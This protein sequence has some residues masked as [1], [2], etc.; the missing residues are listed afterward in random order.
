MGVEPRLR[1]HHQTFT[2]PLRVILGLDP[3]IRSPS[4]S[5]AEVVRAALS[6]QPL[7]RLHNSSVADPRVKPEDDVGEGGN[8]A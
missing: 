4:A 8:A 6:S 5:A 3:G 7:H 2:T 1:L